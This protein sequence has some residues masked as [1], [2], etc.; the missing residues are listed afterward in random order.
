MSKFRAK[1]VISRQNGVKSRLL[2]PQGY[3]KHGP[4]AS[5]ESSRRPWTQPEFTR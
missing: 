5:N 2:E 4:N 3:L 1:S